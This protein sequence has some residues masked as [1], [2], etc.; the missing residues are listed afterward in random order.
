MGLV[1]DAARNRE[2]QIPAVLI[3]LVMVSTWLTHL[4]AAAPDGK[5][6]VQMGAA[7]GHNIGRRMGEPECARILLV[8][9]MVRIF[10]PVPDTHRF[11]LFCSGG[12]HRRGAAVGYAAPGADRT[13]PAT[14]ALLGLEKFSVAVDPVG[15]TPE[16]AGNAWCWQCSLA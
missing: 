3:P 9:G 15:L 5:G 7:I 1:F 4:F 11:G 12:A 13:R 2:A 6:S 16:M 10:W 8:T 14:S